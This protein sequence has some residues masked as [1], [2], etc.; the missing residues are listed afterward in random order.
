MFIL[1]ILYLFVNVV[2]FVNIV[3]FCIFCIFIYTYIYTYTRTRVGLL[4]SCVCFLTAY[5]HISI[6]S[7]L[8][9]AAPES[10]RRKAACEHVAP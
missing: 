5:Y 10:D 3:Y 6:S 4:S 7:A 8:P 1:H 2:Y 9:R